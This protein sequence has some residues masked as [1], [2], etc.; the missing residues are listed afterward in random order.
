MKRAWTSK[1]VSVLITASCAASLLGGCTAARS[2][3]GT[4]DSPCYLALPAAT[5]AVGMHGKLVG[6]H[7][8]TLN[9]LGQRAAPTVR[10]AAGGA[11]IP[12]TGMCDRL[13]RQVHHD[14]SR[15]P[16]RTGIRSLGGGRPGHSVEPAD[17]YRDLRSHAVAVRPF[18]LR[19]MSV[20]PPRSSVT[21]WT[22][23]TTDPAHVLA[24]GQ[25]VGLSPRH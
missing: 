2:E 5:K 13:R 18:P 21:R 23:D 17:R 9:S 15:S 16:L 11:P 4:T 12:T 19:M 10:C 22:S 7:L 6:V 3:L 20:P 24:C 25:G 1:L 14:F 8:L